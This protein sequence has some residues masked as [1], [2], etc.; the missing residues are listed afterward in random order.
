[1]RELGIREND[2]EARAQRRARIAIVDDD[3]AMRESLA[4]LLRSNGFDALALASGAE[5]H[6]LGPRPD[7]D[8]AL[9][10]LKLEG[11]SGLVLAMEIRRS[12][13]LP[14]VML[15][16]VG[17]VVD[18]IV[19]LETGADDFL[20]KPFDPREL[21][22]RIRAV[23][24]RCGAMAAPAGAHHVPPGAG[25]GGQIAF[26]GKCLDLGRRR[27][28]DETGREI[29]LTNAEFRLL[30]FFLRN[31]GRVVPR[32]ELLR[33]LGSDLTQYVDRTI[34]VLILRLRRKIEATPSKPV[35]L[36]TRRGQGYVFVLA[37][38]TAPAGKMPGRA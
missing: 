32:T 12:T 24:R 9:I 10:D 36:Q 4:A 30:E 15:S 25:Q 3:P 33:H 20:M 38:E 35:H 17:D 2:V 14:I 31:P 27:L 19:G 21:L 5:F 16:G 1:M 8:L 28:L 26:G 22:A 37:P 18:K 34:D 13:D 6:A 29:A 7:L 23:L 11:E